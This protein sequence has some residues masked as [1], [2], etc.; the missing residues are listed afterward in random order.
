MK[1]L[2]QVLLQL[3]EIDRR[4]EALAGF[5]QAISGQLGYLVVN[6]AE[7]SVSQRKHIF[8]RKSLDELGQPPLHLRCGLVENK[9]WAV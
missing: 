3:E 6:E 2:L 7:D 8:R 1:K 9:R 5:G 4:D